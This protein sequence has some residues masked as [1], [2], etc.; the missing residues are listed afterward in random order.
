MKQRAL[1]IGLVVA[2]A[3]IGVI[4]TALMDAP[5]RPRPDGYRK[6]WD[7]LPLEK[8]GD[9]AIDTLK[10]GVVQG[11][12]FTSTDELAHCVQKFG[13][14]GASVKLELLVETEQGA[15]HLE[16]VEA[17][18]RADLPPG[19]M[20]CVT[21]ALEAANPVPTPALPE[22]LKWRLELNFLVPPISDLPK[23]QWWQRLMPERWRG[24]PTSHVG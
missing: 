4:I 22:G 24:P 17:E 6:E 20:P 2:G 23:L 9:W 5:Q 19:L 11:E 7:A 8:E 18:P 3:L 21:R 16:Y 13:G 10:R 15:T 1:I 14:S 12:F